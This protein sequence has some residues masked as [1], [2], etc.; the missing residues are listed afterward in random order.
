MNSALYPFHLRYVGKHDRDCNIAERVLKTFTP[1]TLSLLPETLR[2]K[3][4]KSVRTDY[5]PI[6]MNAGDIDAV[7]AKT[8]ESM[9]DQLAIDIPRQFSTLVFGLPDMSPYAVDARIN[10]VSGRQ[11]HLGLRLQ[12]VL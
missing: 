8:L 12:L 10:P 9:K 6:Q 2:Y 5:E 7:H 4:L 1:A 11:R 3:I